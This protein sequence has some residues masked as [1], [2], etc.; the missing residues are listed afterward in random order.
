MPSAPR[1]L[2]DEC[3]GIDQLSTEDE[4]RLLASGQSG[5][6]VSHQICSN[7]QR[8]EKT[9]VVISPIE[10]SG[11]R[12]P[13]EDCI[14]VIQ[15]GAVAQERR[16]VRA[17]SAPSTA[18][19]AQAGTVADFGAGLKKKVFG[20][21]SLKR[22]KTDVAVASADDDAVDEIEDLEE[23]RARVRDFDNNG[24]GKKRKF[25]QRLSSGALSVK[26]WGKK[27]AEKVS[28][29]CCLLWLAYHQLTCVLLKYCHRDSGIA[30]PENEQEAQPLI[31]YPSTSPPSYSFSAPHADSRPMRRATS[32]TTDADTHLR[33][34]FDVSD[35]SE[36][37]HS[38]SDVFDPKANHKRVDRNVSDITEAIQGQEDLG[39]LSN[40]AR[41]AY[42]RRFDGNCTT[43]AQQ[44]KADKSHQQQA[45]LER[46]E[47]QER[48]LRV[49]K[50]ARAGVVVHEGQ[51]FAQAEEPPS[52]RL[53][54]MVSRDT[55]GSIINVTGE[56]VR[57]SRLNCG[58]F[59]A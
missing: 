41:E 15:A 52:L 13:L 43:V 2:V 45:K 8:R 18:Y 36:D 24:S 56:T 10:Q 29:V 31:A 17:V 22:H 27:C 28:K 19:D 44:L 21:F 9:A 4:A 14:S 34:P 51:T 42:F 40:R 1:I 48:T 16:A 6:E 5:V 53:R 35:V 54:R 23:W 58:Q 49:Q 32:V 25:S 7:E 37:D 39:V 12:P 46:K 11:P 20:R 30:S 3:L 55:M 50:E 57:Q 26:A 33:T 47:R 38:N 59:H